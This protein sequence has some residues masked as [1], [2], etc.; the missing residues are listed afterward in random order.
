[1][2]MRPDTPNHVYERYYHI[3]SRREYRNPQRDHCHPECLS[4]Q[5]PV[6]FCLAPIS[7]PALQFFCYSLWHTC[8]VL[9]EETR[10]LSIQKEFLLNKLNGFFVFS[11]TI[12]ILVPHTLHARPSDLADVAVKAILKNV[13]AFRFFDLMCCNPGCII[14][15][16]VNKEVAVQTAVFWSSFC[17]RIHSRI[18]LR[19]ACRY[20]TI[21]GRRDAPALAEA[22]LEDVE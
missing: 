7:S 11:R 20:K 1:M 6:L 5:C 19:S 14:K 18:L 21:F 22:S 17:F 4:G 16:W 13:F 15:V 2:I 12:L 3:H 8:A 10:I 9:V